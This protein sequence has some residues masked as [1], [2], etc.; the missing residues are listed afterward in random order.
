[1]RLGIF[2]WLEIT[3]ILS[4]TSCFTEEINSFVIISPGTIKGMPGG[5][6]Q[7]YSRDA[8]LSEASKESVSDLKSNFL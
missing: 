2:F 7:I 3:S 8:L 4:A 1:M 6:A 5:Y